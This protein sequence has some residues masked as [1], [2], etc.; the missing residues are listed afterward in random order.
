MKKI[1]ILIPMSWDYVPREFMICLWYMQ[2]YSIGKYELEIG[3]NSCC[4][5]HV[6]RQRLADR[7][8]LDCDYML[9]LDADMLYPRDFP[10]IL[11]KHVDNGKSIV[12]GIMLNRKDAQNNAW[13]IEDDKKERITELNQGLVRVDAMGF[14]GVMMKPEV[15]DKLEKPYFSIIF[16]KERE[17]GEDWYFFDKCKEKGIDVWCDT[18]TDVGH[19]LLVPVCKM[20]TKIVGE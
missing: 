9:W 20:Q 6:S 5:L 11:M 7:G 17:V 19:L 14:G 1:N 3:T 2:Q 13:R 4:Y 8:K 10:E 16:D 15:F 12:G 18:D